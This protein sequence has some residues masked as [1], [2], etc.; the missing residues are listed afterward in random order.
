TAYQKAEAGL[1]GADVIET[2]RRERL[3][4]SLWLS[5]STTPATDTAGLLRLATIRDPLAIRA[6]AAA[7]SGSSD[8]P[9]AGVASLLAGAVARATYWLTS[10]SAGDAEDAQSVAARVGAALASVPEGVECA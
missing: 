2:C 5:P 9:V 4:L 7:R 10:A 3:A 8:A 1:T 6:Q